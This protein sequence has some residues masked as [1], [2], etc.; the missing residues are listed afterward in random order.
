MVDSTRASSEA[1]WRQ[2]I[3][4]IAGTRAV[5][6]AAW[7]GETGPAAGW[8]ALTPACRAHVQAFCGDSARLELIAVA[9]ALCLALYR[10]SGQRRVVFAAASLQHEDE[11][12]DTW[13]QSLLVAPRLTFAQA[14][15]LL[16]QDLLHAERQRALPFAMLL[17][18]LGLQRDGHGLFDLLVCHAD[19]QSRPQPAGQTLN[20]MIQRDAA[21]GLLLRAGR[22]DGG[23]PGQAAQRLLERTAIALQAGLA[24]P[25]LPMAQLCLLGARERQRVLQGW[26]P[27]PWPEPLIFIDEWVARHA[28]AHPERTAVLDPVS[29][30]ALDWATLA[31]RSAL[32]AQHLLALGA[33]PEQRIGVCLDASPR[34]LVALL[35]VLQAGCAYVPL[36]PAMPAARLQHIVGDAGIAFIL[37]QGDGPA[38]ARGATPATVID[39][40]DIPE[41]PPAAARVVPLPRRHGQQLAYVIYTSGS[42]GR[43]KGVMI[44]HHNLANY[45]SFAVRCY[46]LEAGQGVPLS[47]SPS[48]DLSVT[49]LLAP[50]VAGQPVLAART[51][52]QLDG[53]QSTLPAWPG[54]SLLKAT[55]SQLL[56]LGDALA[57]AVLR[58]ATR[59]LVVGGEALHERHLARWRA[60]CPGLRVVNEYGPT[61]ITVGCSVHES[62]EAQ[63][64]GVVPIGRP[65]ANTRMYLLDADLQPVPDE[66]PGEIFVGGAGVARGYH[67][68]GALTAERFVPDPFAAV[69]GA[70]MYR[71][72]DLAL[73]RADGE[74]VFLGRNDRQIKLRGWR[75][76]PGEIEAALLEL[77]G[78]RAAA[79]GLRQESPLSAQLV[80]WLVPEGTPPTLGEIQ[81]H[82][83]LRLPEYML[84]AVVLAVDA[85]PL[86]AGG[87]VDHARL[88]DS[89]KPRP[90]PVPGP[91]TPAAEGAE[92]TLLQIWRAVLD[93]PT[94]GVDD[95]FLEF[96]GDSIISIR[97]VGRARQAGLKIRPSQLFEHPTVAA[98][99]QVAE[100]WVETGGDVA[101]G[102]GP[103]PLTPIQHLYF[104]QAGAHPAPMAQTRRFELGTRLGSAQ[105]HA[106]LALVVQRH[107]A[108]RLRF[109]RQDGLWVQSVSANEASPLL[110][111]LDVS[112]LDE[113][114]RE[115]AWCTARDACVARL[116]I[117]AG[118]LLQAVLVEC[119]TGQSQQFFVAVHHLAID[120]LSWLPLIDELHAALLDPAAL[121]P[122]GTSF[123]RW[124]RLLQRQ[125][126]AGA[127]DDAARAWLAEPT[128]AG[129]APQVPHADPAVARGLLLELD[130]ARTQQL[131]RGMHRAYNTD[132]RD[133]L[134]AALALAA[135]RQS[136][137]DAVLIDLESSGREPFADLID[138]SRSIGWFSALFPLA[139]YPDRADPLL[140]TLV[141]VKEQLRRVPGNG[142]AFGAM[143]WLRP[144]HPDARR[145][146]DR[147]QAEIALNHLGRVDPETRHVGLLQPLPGSYGQDRPLA[148]LPP[149]RFE[150]NTLVVQDRLRIELVHLAGQEAAARALADGFV[151]ALHAL[152]D[153]CMRL[154]G[155][156]C[157]PAD[158]PLADIDATSLSALLDEL[159]SHSGAPQ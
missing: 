103:L 76:E 82:L 9:T 19:L 121:A 41:A 49:A 124:A 102:T 39:V 60:A 81:R 142:S 54:L 61:E 58:A 67:G 137:A 77:R 33:T 55:P 52:L 69:P 68:R 138:T 50:L 157:T 71:T 130:E 78:V 126:E 120:H 104:A 7:P 107:D 64:G 27:E 72:S 134:V 3:A 36:D 51:L 45:L 14:L 48:F 125:A 148:L 34:L 139:V 151:E 145:L 158:F 56:A 122:P 85:L 30:E 119:G 91:A 15:G 146:R 18:A 143:R 26:N 59:C 98:L 159:E 141:R 135:T 128:P 4:A 63:P 108:L 144:D 10:D 106:A 84:P 89:L 46:K 156:G 62:T 31:S 150:F 105:L 136:G 2:R 100:P 20:I 123:A 115:R 118:P 90:A 65:I 32:L 12:P 127:F 29:G 131:L 112:A 40:A 87:K 99:A 92:A 24:E 88:V 21:G 117:T 96:G 114:G 79:V 16:R 66:T 149:H 11:A 75:I 22:A 8:L 153:R 97:V 129:A 73:R 110:R 83:R 95:N 35:G 132:V 6:P 74:L 57:P 152:L 23:A 109:A 42:S 5:L 17:D 1:Y 155:P 80:A 140:G 93:A 113:P 25:E 133:A 86:A 53:L 154:D 44:S 111:L 43:P 101:D 147:A 94:L 116:D 47:S 37:G 70:R 38:S 13:V 28:A